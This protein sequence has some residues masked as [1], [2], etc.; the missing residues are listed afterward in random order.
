MLRILFSLGKLIVALALMAVVCTLAW[1]GLVNGKLYDCTDGGSLDFWFVG[2]WVHHPITVQHVVTGRST[3]EPDTIQAG[4]SVGRL[5]LLWWSF[6][7]VS[8]IVSFACACISWLPRIERSAD[9]LYAR[10][11]EINAQ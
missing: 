7:A 10:T 1:D 2:D 4:W 8:L 3:N 5:R 9:W 6:V 11:Q